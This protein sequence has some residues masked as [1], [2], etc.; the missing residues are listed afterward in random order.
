MLAVADIGVV[1][2]YRPAHGLDVVPAT[3]R[4][5]G[6]HPQSGIALQ[7]RVPIAI[8]ALNVQVF[9]DAHAP[10]LNVG[11][12]VLR[13]RKV[14]VLPVDADVR[15][16]D[17]A[18][19]QINQPVAG[20]GVA[21]VEQRVAVPPIVRLTVVAEQEFR[22]LPEQ[23]GALVDALRLKPH[24]QL[25]ALPVAFLSDGR[26]SVREML[27]VRIPVSCRRPVVVTGIPAGINPPYIGNQTASPVGVNGSFLIFLGHAAEFRQTVDHPR[28]QDQ[29]GGERRAVFARQN[30]CEVEGAPQIAGAILPAG[31]C[32]VGHT[33]G[34]DGLTRL[35]VGGKCR[36]SCP[37]RDGISGAKHV[38][39]PCACP[40]D[41]HIDTPIAEA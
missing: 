31:V 26:E 5:A 14:E 22:M 32:L 6:V 17:D 13:R 24:Q 11:I 27:G 3:A 19:H 38:H 36:L 35:E 20:G 10:F 40:A 28:V 37:E 16:L 4:G 30:V 1:Q 18:V 25:D 34:A 7:Q 12:P 8:V 33:R 39:P 21:E 2:R 29:L 23:L 41:S 15:L 9:T